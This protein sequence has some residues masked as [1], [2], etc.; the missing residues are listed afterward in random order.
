MSESQSPMPQHINAKGE[1]QNVGILR[2]GYLVKE[3]QMT[4]YSEYSMLG[5]RHRPYP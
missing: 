5:W 1:R 4:E 2:A 3:L